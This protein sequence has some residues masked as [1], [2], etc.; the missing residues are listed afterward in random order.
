MQGE[1]ATLESS[2]CI[3]RTFI[4]QNIMSKKFKLYSSRDPQKVAGQEFKEL[5]LC[6]PDQAL[7]VSDILHNF[8]VT[9]R[10]GI[11]DEE[12]IIPDARF[13]D[14]L[15]QE[16]MKRGVRSRLAEY[17]E[18]MTDADAPSEPAPSGS[19]PNQPSDDKPDASKADNPEH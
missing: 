17:Q 1:W 11:Y 5:S 6:E 12:G 2:P 14:K 15:E 8:R 19:Q 18:R 4:Y 10:T 16:D 9:G 7:P 13:M 3:K